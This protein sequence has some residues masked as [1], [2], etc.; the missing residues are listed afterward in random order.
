MQ[1]AGEVLR[2]RKRVSDGAFLENSDNSR[3]EMVLTCCVWP[4]TFPLPGK[5]VSLIPTVILGYFGKFRK[6]K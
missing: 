5:C 6:Y 1:T 4:L 3:P 2:S